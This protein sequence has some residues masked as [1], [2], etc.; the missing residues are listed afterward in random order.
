MFEAC[1]GVVQSEKFE[2]ERK[3]Q[4]T[5]CCPPSRL[6]LLRL[7][8]TVNLPLREYLFLYK[9]H[10]SSIQENIFEAFKVHCISHN[11]SKL[12][13]CLFLKNLQ[14]K[15]YAEDI[16]RK[17]SS[18]HFYQMVMSKRSSLQGSW[19]SVRYIDSFCAG[20]IGSL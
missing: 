14:P 10:G 18:D 11:L 16:V 6:G 17:D 13:L 9:G 4:A 8:F 3:S 1:P 2:V 19:K 20:T 12:R 5:P 7:L 15:D